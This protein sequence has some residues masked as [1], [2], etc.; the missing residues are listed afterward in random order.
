V[1]VVVA[2]MMLL[3]AAR[4]TLDSDNATAAINHA[5]FF[6]NSPFHCLIFDNKKPLLDM[7]KGR[8]QTTAAVRQARNPL[9]TPDRQGSSS[10][11]LFSLKQSKK[12][13]DS[14]KEGDAVS[15]DTHRSCTVRIYPFRYDDSENGIYF[16]TWNCS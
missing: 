7:E 2:K 14:L 9:F 13:S 16:L 5:I 4:A 3:G 11:K 8:G 15:G 1:L 10:A 6:M 12:T